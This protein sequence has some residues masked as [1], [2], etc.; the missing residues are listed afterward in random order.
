M[1]TVIIKCGWHFYQPFYTDIFYHCKSFWK[2]L[3]FLPT[4]YFFTIERAG[5]YYYN[6][7]PPR[8]VAT[9][10]PSVKK[11]VDSQCWTD[12]THASKILL[13]GW[14][15]WGFSFLENKK[16]KKNLCYLLLVFVY[17]ILI[18][19]YK[20]LIIAFIMFYCL[21]YYYNVMF[22]CIYYLFNLLIL[23]FI[24]FFWI[25]SFFLDF[26]YF[27]IYCFLDFFDFFDFFRFSIILDLLLFFDFI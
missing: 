14:G 7:L 21:L 16:K 11:I 1:R 9:P 20:Q 13:T 25:Y 15:L 17:I 26:K 18:S 10:P 3:A 27:W 2:K 19:F 24:I 23:C 8:W 5:V 6:F 22:I 12:K 4:I